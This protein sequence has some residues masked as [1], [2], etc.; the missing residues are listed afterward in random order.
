[1]RFEHLNLHCESSLPLPGHV[2]EAL[3]AFGQ[4]LLAFLP[5]I[6]LLLY[7]NRWFRH[8]KS[9]TFGHLKRVFNCHSDIPS[10]RL[11]KAL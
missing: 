10:I 2:L 6:F 5:H 8:C 3:T 1:M 11:C 4:V 7:L 9:G